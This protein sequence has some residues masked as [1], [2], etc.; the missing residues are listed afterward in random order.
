MTEIN[1]SRIRFR[2]FTP[3]AVGVFNN[4]IA[5]A[6]SLAEK[7]GT[8]QG[9]NVG[10]NSET[11]E[12]VMYGGNTAWYEWTAE[13]DGFLTIETSPLSGSDVDTAIT[14]WTT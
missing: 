7:S 6:T 13:E 14:V 1:L 3:N 2:A 8:V 4:R 12:P 9:S 5:R 10:F 11:D